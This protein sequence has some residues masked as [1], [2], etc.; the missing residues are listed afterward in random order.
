[1]RTVKVMFANGNSLITDINGTRAEVLAYYVGQWFN[2]G[3]S[4]EGS[5]DDM[6]RAVSVEFLE[7]LVCGK[8]VQVDLSGIGHCWKDDDTIPPDVRIEI[9]CEI[10]DGK[11]E[12]CEDYLASNGLHYRWS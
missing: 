6:Q 8:R 1:M 11:Q 10:I 4:T 3:P 5:D 7:L 2:L 9:E 12:T